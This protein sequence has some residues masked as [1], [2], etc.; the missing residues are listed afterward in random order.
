L[1]LPEDDFQFKEY[2]EE[3]TETMNDEIINHIIFYKEDI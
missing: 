3:I 1:I 2:I